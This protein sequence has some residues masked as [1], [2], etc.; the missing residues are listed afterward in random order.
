MLSIGADSLV[1]VEQNASASGPVSNSPSIGRTPIRYRYYSSGLTCNPTI[2][3]IATRVTL[4]NCRLSLACLMAVLFATFLYH[5]A[6][7]Q[8]SRWKSIG[9]PH[10]T[11]VHI[12]VDTD[13]RAHRLDAS[14]TQRLSA[15]TPDGVF[16]STGTDRWRLLQTSP[17]SKEAD[18]FLLHP[19]NGAS[20]AAISSEGTIEFVCVED[21][22]RFAARGFGHGWRVLS[23]DNCRSRPTT[24]YAVI[25]DNSLLERG[26]QLMKST[27]GGET[28]ICVRGWSEYT[29]M[30]SL[31]DAKV[32][33]LNS[34]VVYLV[35]NG[36]GIS[37]LVKTINGGLTWQ[38]T[39][40]GGS[41]F[42]C[43][44]LAVDP[45]NSRTVYVLGMVLG[46]ARVYKSCDGLNSI[47]LTRRIDKAYTLAVHPKESNHLFVLAYPHELYHSSDGGETWDT[48]DTSAL[49]DNVALALT[50]DAQGDIYVGTARN[51]VFIRKAERNKPRFSHSPPKVLVTAGAAKK[52]RKQ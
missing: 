6:P 13:N 12:A 22:R 38:G 11:V 52:D 1:P 8:E 16:V 23:L 24:M 29:N 19:R 33:P 3:D 10:A 31:L 49:N 50:V 34:D 46:D 15:Q 18:W 39:A 20:T 2:F 36:G 28:W 45:N 9:P 48:L 5:P 32:D 27:D 44:D 43:I 21:S 14:S 47:T 7:G 40:L 26:D 35:V 4:R 30:T 25:E 37:R 42:D 41:L 17:S 51:G